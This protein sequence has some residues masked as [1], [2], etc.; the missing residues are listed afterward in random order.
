MERFA[1]DLR[2]TRAFGL[3]LL[4]HWR[5]LCSCTSGLL[6]PSKVGLLLFTA[7]LVQGGAGKGKGEAE[8][9]SDHVVTWHVSP[10]ALFT[11]K[12]SALE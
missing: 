1:P 8:A 12:G 6:L 4:G 7:D 10:A 11:H 9:D 5:R 2:L 3:R